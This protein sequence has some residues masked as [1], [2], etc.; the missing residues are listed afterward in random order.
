M[1]QKIRKKD[2]LDGIKS[3]IDRC[4]AYQKADPDKTAQKRADRM[5]KSPCGEKRFYV[6]VTLKSPEAAE[7]D[8]LPER[9]KRAKVKRHLANLDEMKKA[10]EAGCVIEVG[11]SRTAPLSFSVTA[12]SCYASLMG[13]LIQK[14]FDESCLLLALKPKKSATSDSYIEDDVNTALAAGKSRIVYAIG[15]FSVEGIKA[16]VKGEYDAEK[17]DIWSF[18]LNNMNGVGYVDM[19]RRTALEQNVNQFF[20]DP[21]TMNSVTMFGAKSNLPSFDLKRQHAVYDMC[22][23][24]TLKM[25]EVRAGDDAQAQKKYKFYTEVR[26]EVFRGKEEAMHAAFKGFGG[27]W[28]DWGTAESQFLTFKAVSSYDAEFL[29]EAEANAAFIGSVLAYE[30]T[31]ALYGNSPFP[32]MKGSWKQETDF[33]RQKAPS[34]IGFSGEYSAEAKAA[35]ASFVSE[36]MVDPPSVVVEPYGDSQIKFNSSIFYRF[37]VPAKL[38]VSEQAYLSADARDPRYP[39]LGDAHSVYAKVDGFFKSKNAIPIKRETVRLEGLDYQY[40]GVSMELDRDNSA[41]YEDEFTHEGMKF[42][43]PAKSY[44][45]E[46]ERAYFDSQQLDDRFK[47]CSL[48]YELIPKT[49]S[50]PYVFIQDSSFESLAKAQERESQVREEW[51]GKF[52]RCCVDSVNYD[53][54]ITVTDRLKTL[55]CVWAKLGAEDG[56]LVELPPVEL[57]DLSGETCGKCGKP[58]PEC[59]CGDVKLCMKCYPLDFYGVTA[60]KGIGRP[61]QGPGSSVYGMLTAV[62]HMYSQANS[63]MSF[64]EIAK[65][66]HMA[67]Y[68]E[69]APVEEFAMMSQSSL[70]VLSVTYQTL[71][72]CAQFQIGG[73]VAGGFSED[74]W[75]RFVREYSIGLSSGKNMGSVRFATEFKVGV[76][77]GYAYIPTGHTICFEFDT[78]SMQLTVRGA[79]PVQMAMMAALAAC[80]EEQYMAMW[81]PI[82]E[83]C[84]PLSDDMKKFIAYPYMPSVK[85]I[86]EG[87]EE[88]GGGPDGAEET[89][90][91]IPDPSDLAAALTGAAACAQVRFSIY[92]RR[93]VVCSYP[94]DKSPA[95]RAKGTEGFCGLREL[96]EKPLTVCACGFDLEGEI[97]KRQTRRRRARM[98]GISQQ[99]KEDTQSIKEAACSVPNN[100]QRIDDIQSAA[101]SEI[102]DFMDSRRALF[103]MVGRD[104][105]GGEGQGSLLCEALRSQGLK[106]VMLDYDQVFMQTA[107]SIELVGDESFDRTK[108][109]MAGLVNGLA[110]ADDVAKRSLTET[111][112]ALP[113]FMVCS[114]KYSDYLT[115]QNLPKSFDVNLVELAKERHLREIEQNAATRT[116]DNMIMENV[117]A[118]QGLPQS[119][120]DDLTESLKGGDFEA[121]KSM[122]SAH[123]PLQEL[124]AEGKTADEKAMALL[125]KACKCNGTKASLLASVRKEAA[126][127]LGN[128]ASSVKRTIM[129]KFRSPLNLTE[130]MS[131]VVSIA[132]GAAKMGKAISNGVSAGVKEAIGEAV[133]PLL[134]CEP[135]KGDGDG[136]SV[137]DRLIS[138]GGMDE[139]VSAAKKASP[140]VKGLQKALSGPKEKL[141]ET[142]C[143]SLVSNVMSCL[144][145]YLN[146]ASIGAAALGSLGSA[147]SSSGGV[148]AAATAGAS[149]LVTGLMNTAIKGTGLKGILGVTLG[150]TLSMVEKLVP[151][152][153]AKAPQCAESIC[154]SLPKKAGGE[155]AA[156]LDKALDGKLAEQIEGI[157]DKVKENPDM[158]SVIESALKKENGAM[159]APV[160]GFC[161]G[162][163]S[164]DVKSQ[165]NSATRQTLQDESCAADALTQAH[166]FIRDS[167]KLWQ[168]LTGEFISFDSVK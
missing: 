136:G 91:Y 53:P 109:E 113:I 87:A 14:Y 150:D 88:K 70:A 57:T 139:M 40:T 42:T 77:D 79:T 30:K 140:G 161:N 32:A 92:I 73:S 165:G 69:S 23:Y 66:I 153:A 27:V 142:I 135:P 156:N 62:G 9:L 21:G 94:K 154:E 158:N 31:M 133:F 115:E 86:I 132:A 166:K 63:P 78:M 105:T 16:M 41:P 17:F 123:K 138:E 68:S 162:S 93:P 155:I 49:V 83:A 106:S 59:E 95:C 107:N 34:D 56:A 7:T 50:L 90:V 35:A 122:I 39:L 147:L 24:V 48:R 58:K 75:A 104:R 141:A 130:G 99:L 2:I 80:G 146:T 163:S 51:K 45:N 74:S 160:M 120:K 25:D 19:T 100:L 1:G 102:I 37:C 84:A 137:T 103:G 118:I 98:K 143:S 26:D 111:A 29:K 112:L 97:A 44:Y 81:R 4:L 38:G 152:V 159:Q 36:S 89:Y 12:H 117:M 127:A 72:A 134:G 64:A 60:L 3:E 20:R 6:N 85:G 33:F 131:I 18:R 28:A 47:F 116:G 129:T 167:A 149:Q 46:A 10:F 126:G 101:A 11:V 124:A 71:Q 121:V 13:A 54:W 119:A 128:S 110:A 164:F 82:A 55:F 15:R 76:T 151:G 144:S 8:K 61:Q 5:D 65:E 96:F 157:R 148:K 108:E 67:V 145:Q 168:Q 22:T 114:R 52:L 125:K 43:V